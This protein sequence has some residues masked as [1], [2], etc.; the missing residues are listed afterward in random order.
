MLI[1]IAADHGGFELKAQLIADLKTA[2]MMWRTSALMIW[3]PEMTTLIL[4]CLC[5]K[6]WR[7]VRLPGVW[8]SAAAVWGRALRPIRCRRACSV[9]H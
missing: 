1:G 9:D 3:L 8:P 6:R 7:K 2:G 4:L 5:P